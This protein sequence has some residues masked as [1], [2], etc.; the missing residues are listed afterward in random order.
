MGV[1]KARYRPALNRAN[2]GRAFAGVV[3]VVVRRWSWRQRLKPVGVECLLLSAILSLLILCAHVAV[4][5]TLETLTQELTGSGS[6]I[7]VVQQA[8]N[9]LGGKGP[10]EEYI[11]S[12]DHRLTIS[13]CGQARAVVAE[14]RWDLVSD[15]SGHPTLVISDVGK[16]AVKVSSSS[17]D[18][19]L[20]RLQP[21][22]AT[23]DSSKMLRSTK[24]TVNQS[25]TGDCSPAIAGVVGGNIV[26]SGIC[27]GSLN[28]PAPSL[29]AVDEALNKLVEGN[30]AFEAPDKA[31]VGKSQTIEARLSFSKTPG[32]LVS[33]LN[34]PG[35]KE[36]A[37][38]RA[39][40]KMAATLSGAGAFDVSPSGPQVQ[41]I[42]HRDTTIWKWTVTPKVT[43]PQFLVLSFD[44]VLTVNEKEGTRTITTLTRKIDVQIG[45][46]ET[47]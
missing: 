36:S 14:H 45:W 21:A 37:S 26:T 32:E 23:K 12:S 25:T 24:E 20:L 8:T 47:D 17:D 44:A 38:L 46:P 35:R 16:F 15:D 2:E 33:E 40:D 27:T 19:T 39:G 3:R 31:T 5:Q 30:V 22:S 13:T 43:G 18:D 11:F 34:G 41:L 29:S 6:K 28:L 7:W 4:A 42:S 1:L 10:C 9:S